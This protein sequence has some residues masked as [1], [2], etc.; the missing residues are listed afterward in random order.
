MGAV[1]VHVGFVAGIGFLELVGA[2]LVVGV[3]M[4]PVRDGIVKAEFHIAAFAGFGELFKDVSFARGVHNVEVGGLRVPHAEAVMVLRGDDDVFRAERL[5]DVYELV[6]VEM[7]G[8][9]L[10]EVFFVFGFGEA[11][12]HPFLLVVAADRIDAPMDEHAE[13][14]VEHLPGV[15]ISLEGNEGKQ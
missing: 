7:F 4:V 12:L 1:F 5:G 9:E 8:G 13:P 11:K 6:R 15:G 2:E 14:A 10:W 3:G